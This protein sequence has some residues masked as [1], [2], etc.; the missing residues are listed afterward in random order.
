MGGGAN[1]R[2]Y[3]LIFGGVNQVA[4]GSFGGAV[5]CDFMESHGELPILSFE[6]MVESEVLIRG[7]L[8]RFCCDEAR[9]RTRHGLGSDVRAR[10]GRALCG[11]QLRDGEIPNSCTFLPSGVLTLRMFLRFFRTPCQA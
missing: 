10:Q 9:V 11:V 4:D 8:A 1:A 7:I 3:V 5:L 2:W 6:I